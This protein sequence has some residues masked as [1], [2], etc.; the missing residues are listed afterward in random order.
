MSP[1]RV[2]ASLLS[3]VVLAGIGACGKDEVR[4][5][6]DEPQP[7]QSAVAGKRIVVPD[8]LAPLD[9]SREMP[10]PKAETPPRPPGLKC[11]EYPP[12]IN[13]GN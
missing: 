3:L 8:D 7:Y 5:T 13:A 11:I 10:V 6:C 1:I 2:S 4:T 9:E 12:S